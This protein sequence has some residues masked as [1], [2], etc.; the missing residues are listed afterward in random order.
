M[1]GSEDT[2]VMERN[3]VKG[4]W[5]V[6]PSLSVNLSIES[7]IQPEAPIESLRAKRHG[8]RW[9]KSAVSL[10]MECGLMKWEKLRAASDDYIPRDASSFLWPTLSLLQASYLFYVLAFLF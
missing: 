9:R 2:K 3:C 10:R 7:K 5:K 8:Q 1:L 4:L 6:R